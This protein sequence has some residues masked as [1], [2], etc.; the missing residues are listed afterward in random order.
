M[1]EIKFRGIRLDNGEW[2]YGFLF[3]SWE[4]RYI[5][6]GTTNDIPNIIEVISE[7]A[8]QYT[9]LKDKNGK[10]IYEGDILRGHGN[11]KDLAQVCL[12][13]FYVIDVETLAKVDEV[14]G[15]YTKVLPMDEISK[16][17]PFCLDMPLTDFYI[18]RA[19][20]EIIG[21]IYENPE[22]LNLEP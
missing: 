21:N 17:E 11:D 13:N 14:H 22:L 10:E 5:L 4:R 8:S 19:E 12:G 15:W 9:G 7:S 18:D 20:Y 3:G 1:R 2:V 6:W 16:I